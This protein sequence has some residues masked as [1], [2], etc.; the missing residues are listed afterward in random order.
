MNSIRSIAR[1]AM[2]GVTVHAPTHPVNI[3][4]FGPKNPPT[5]INKTFPNNSFQ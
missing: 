2:S 1:I 5:V 3:A 4:Q